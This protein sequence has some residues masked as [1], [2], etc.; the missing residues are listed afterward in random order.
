MR[1]ALDTSKENQATARTT[2]SIR[3]TNARTTEG[4]TRS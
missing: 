3:W 2:F 4:T 1:N